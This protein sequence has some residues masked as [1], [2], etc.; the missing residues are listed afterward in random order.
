MHRDEIAGANKDLEFREADRVGL[1]D[2]GGAQHH[3]V[4]ITVSLKLGALIAL[5][6]VLYR[7]GME[8]EGVGEFIQLIRR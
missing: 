6:S 4:R 7:K 1:L 3:E 5:L 2:R 8:A